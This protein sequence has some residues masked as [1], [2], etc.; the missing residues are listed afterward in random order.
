VFTRK[1]YIPGMTPG[2][3]FNRRQLLRSTMIGG[4]AAGLPIGAATPAAAGPALLRVDRPVLTHGVQSGGMLERS[5]LV[6][7]RAD[8]LSR[9]LVEV[10]TRPDLNDACRIAGPVLTADTDYTGKVRVRG[11]RGRTVYYGTVA[12]RDRPPDLLHPLAQKP[13]ERPSNVRFIGVC[14]GI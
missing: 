10:S 2:P 8:R 13:C 7:A 9:L 14:Q 6:W 11:D 5:G 1:G 3:V 12:L 4:L